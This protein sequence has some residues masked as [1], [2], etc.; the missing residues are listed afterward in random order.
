[1]EQDFV[2]SYDYLA[3][4]FY[5]PESIPQSWL[6]W[7]HGQQVTM[8][9]GGAVNYCP[10]FAM[11]DQVARAQDGID[12]ESFGIDTVRITAVSA[13]GEAVVK[14]VE[15]SFDANGALCAS[16]VSTET[17]PA[18][19]V[20][21]IAAF[22][23]DPVPLLALDT[24]PLLSEQVPR[25]AEAAEAYRGILAGSES[26]YDPMKGEDYTLA[27]WFG[28]YYDSSN[29]LR[30]PTDPEVVPKLISIVAADLD[31]DGIPEIIIGWQPSS[32]EKPRQLDWAENFLILHYYDGQVS[33]VS[34][35]LRGFN[36]LRVNGVIA[37][38]E[39]ETIPL[40]PEVR[41]RFID[42][43]SS[44]RPY[45][46]EYYFGGPYASD[47]P[48]ARWHEYTLQNVTRLLNE[49]GG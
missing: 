46:Y 9:P 41:L 10:T 27:E 11:L 32:M 48:Y 3:G 25:S 49:L 31:D 16:I 7:E 33:G 18:G 44:G 30:E 28:I 1:A 36:G 22:D 39:R 24:K 19:D 14:T 5:D 34:T 2:D 43:I 38:H 20:P 21:E 23:D 13:S 40:Y 35:V 37:N 29:A 4:S 15:M 47:V 42:D 12:F 45:E 26:F 6:Y 8:R 17:V